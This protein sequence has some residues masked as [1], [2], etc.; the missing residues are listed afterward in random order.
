MIKNFACFTYSFEGGPVCLKLQREGWNVKVG[1]IQDKKDILTSQENPSEEPEEDKKRRL[2][3]FDGLLDKMTAEELVSFLKE[4]PEDQRN[5]WFIF[6]DLNHCFKY[7]EQLKGLGFN[8]QFSTQ[9]DRLFE[10]DRDMAKTF[11]TENYPDIE[12]GRV[13]DFSS[14]EE[15]E[16]FGKEENDEIYVLKGKDEDAPT[17]VPKSTD[18]QLAWEE[19]E[20]ALKKHQD[21]YEKAGFILEVKVSDAVEHTGQAVF[22][23]GELVYLMNDIEAKPKG[24]GDVG[25]L[26][27]CS[28][29]LTFNVEEDDRLSE[30]CF[31][32]AVYKMAKKHEGLFVWDASLLISRRTGKIYFGEFCANRVGYNCFYSELAR[33]DTVGEWFNK[34]VEGIDPYENAPIF[35][36]S[37]RIFSDEMEHGEEKP[38]SKA[39]IGVHYLN[40]NHFWPMDMRSIDGK[41]QTAG[42]SD[43]V[44]IITG[45]GNTITELAQDIYD[46]VSQFTMDCNRWTYRYRGDYT[47]IDYPTSIVSRYNFGN[48]H[49]YNKPEFQEDKDRKEKID[50]IKKRL[51]MIYEQKHKKEIGKIKRQVQDIINEPDEEAEA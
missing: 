29:D 32:Q 19:I 7:A 31:P 33:L 3:C 4:I 49:L 50:D 15:A 27:G 46:N 21:H 28:A 17:V 43:D 8:G 25:Q 14:V 44:C 1:V 40:D 26:T 24:A 2:S 48:G 39:G 20:A 34:V 35:S 47:A 37:V 30:I 22:Y 45:K 12:D 5:N 16:D 6:P 36:G 13:F 41:D 18:P 38:Q 10:V 51:E 23:N 9:E 42:Y 11:V